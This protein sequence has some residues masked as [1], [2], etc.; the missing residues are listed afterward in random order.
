[1]AFLTK[2]L[3]LAQQHYE[4]VVLGLALAALAVSGFLLA[5]QKEKEEEELKNYIVDVSRRK[6]YPYTN[7]VWA[8]YMAA[9]TEGTKP[10][11]MDFTKPRLHNLFGPVKWQRSSG[12][13]G[14]LLKIELGNEVGPEALKVTSITPLYLN[15]ALNKAGGGSGY[16]INVTREASTN[17]L[18]RRKIESYV[19][20]GSKD[21][22]GTFLLREVKGTPEEPE[23]VL[24]L[25]DSGEKV[26]LLKNTPVRKVEGYKADL[27]Y[28]PENNRTFK[29]KRVGDTITVAG[30][31]YNLVAI[32][33]NEVVLSSR[34]NYKQTTLR[35]NAAL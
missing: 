33:E 9:L 5:Q 18:W 31:D 29:E 1:M 24:E 27:V 4:K 28:P 19:T 30:E 7:M 21:R 23:L 6:P 22:I 2:L 26:S 8:T 20:P 25:L 13:E 10:V 15:I 32:T 35:H 34:S 16:F 14:K 11:I 12:P 3:A 17:L